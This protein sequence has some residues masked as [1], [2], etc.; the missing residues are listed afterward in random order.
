MIGHPDMRRQIASDRQAELVRRVERSQAV[1][2]A[3]RT[4][5]PPEVLSL[6]PRPRLRRLATAVRAVVP[7]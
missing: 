4:A 5:E 2:D 1:R 7:G 6:M 3:R